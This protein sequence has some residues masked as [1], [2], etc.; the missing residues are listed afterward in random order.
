MED[1]LIENLIK[2][3]KSKVFDLSAIIPFVKEAVQTLVQDDFSKCFLS[4]KPD[5]WN[6]NL[7]L[8]PLWAFGVLFR[9]IILLPIRMLILIGG[10]IISIAAFAVASVIL[11]GKTR[12][13]Y[14]RFLIRFMC[15]IF[16]ASWTGVVRYHGVIPARKMNQIYV[17]NHSSMIDLIILQQMNTFA[18]V[19]QQ[20][21]GWVAF[22]Q[23]KV[24]AC[25]GCI[26]FD[27]ASMTDKTE[28]GIFKN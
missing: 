25:L 27:R 1:K 19:G 2:E 6:W 8:Y 13:K 17:S 14:Q 20:H 23:N 9:Y 22:L 21:K 15:S 24:L 28:T 11:S 3:D 10:L 26:W 16:V 12:D 7:Y 5:P 4:T 18:A